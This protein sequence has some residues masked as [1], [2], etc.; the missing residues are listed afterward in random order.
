MLVVDYIGAKCA[1]LRRVTFRG[2]TS[3]CLVLDF[4]NGGQDGGEAV[5]VGLSCVR[6]EGD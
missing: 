4:G 2:I 3:R 6:V 1:S 5:R